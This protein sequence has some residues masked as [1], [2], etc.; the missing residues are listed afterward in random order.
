M[1]SSD[2][3]NV[4]LYND[5]L[6]MF[7]QA[8]EERP[9]QKSQHSWSMTW[10]QQDILLKKEPRSYQR[11]RTMVN[12]ILE[13]QQQNMLISHQKKRSKDSSSSILSRRSWREKAWRVD[14]GCQKARPRK[15][16]CVHSNMTR[17]RKEKA[18]EID[19]EAWFK[20]ASHQN[21]NMPERQGNRPSGKEDRPLC[22][23]CNRG[24]CS[25]DRERDYWHPPHWQILP[26][27]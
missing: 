10:N 2:S 8:C 5:N 7:N 23:N 16:E 22:C 14:L 11:L 25:H 19:Q 6:K 21:E 15:A 13:E 4:E 12:D 17:H 1:H 24:N 27:G 18:K 26:E 20:E 9:S 3:L